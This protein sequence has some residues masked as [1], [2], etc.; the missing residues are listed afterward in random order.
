MTH[1]DTKHMLEL[2]EQQTGYRV[3]V[4]MISGIHDHARMISARK[5]SRSSAASFC[6]EPFWRWAG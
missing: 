6:W 1:P 3:C 4:D 2:V 5:A